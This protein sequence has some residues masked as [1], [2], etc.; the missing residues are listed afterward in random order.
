MRLDYLNLYYIDR[1]PPNHLQLVHLQ[2]GQLNYEL[3]LNPQTQLLRSP[4]TRF[5]PSQLPYIFEYQLQSTFHQNYHTIYQNPFFHIFHC[6]RTTDILVN[7]L[8]GSLKCL[9]FVYLFYFCGPLKHFLFFGSPYPVSV[10]PTEGGLLSPP[11]YLF[12]S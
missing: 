10:I 2:F 3:S 4:K 5:L 9:L 12:S 11:I 6:M 8:V 7:H 1:Q